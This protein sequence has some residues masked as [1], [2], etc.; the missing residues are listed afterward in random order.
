MKP[1]VQVNKIKLREGKSFAHGHTANTFW[2]RNVSPVCQAQIQ[3]ALPCVMVASVSLEML[4]QALL[5]LGRP[6][7]VF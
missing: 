6:I 4:G 2:S 5:P 1:L 3:G 7:E